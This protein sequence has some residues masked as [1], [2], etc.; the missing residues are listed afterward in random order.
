M[1]IGKIKLFMKSYI[2][3][4]HTYLNFINVYFF[5]YR[6]CPEACTAPLGPFLQKLKELQIPSGETSNEPEVESSESSPT[7]KYLR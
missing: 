2:K 4:V 1:I 7:Q 3:Y 6:L 5:G